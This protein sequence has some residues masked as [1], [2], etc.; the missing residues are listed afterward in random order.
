M[1]SIDEGI[2]RSHRPDGVSSAVSYFGIAVRNQ[3]NQLLRALK[4]P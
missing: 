1:R 2:E 4:L 3:T